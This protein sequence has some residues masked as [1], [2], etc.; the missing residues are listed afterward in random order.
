M[1][2]KNNI[3]QNRIISIDVTAGKKAN[4]LYTRYIPMYKMASF[5]AMKNSEMNMA[6]LTS[7]KMLCVLQYLKSCRQYL[8][9]MYL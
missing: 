1:D 2:L 9:K 3:W 5:L 4:F 8:G 6:D 7:P